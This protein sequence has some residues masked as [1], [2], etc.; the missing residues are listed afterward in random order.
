[1]RQ[2]I[3]AFKTNYAEEVKIKSRI[4]I[5]WEQIYRGFFV[6]Y[7]VLA[8]LCV[9]TIAFAADSVPIKIGYSAL[10]ISLPV[11]SAFKQGFF[12]D[13]GLDVELVRFDTAQPLM[14]SLVAGNIQVAGYTALPITFNSMLRS[15]TK[16]YFITSLYEDQNHPISYVIVPSDTPPSFQLTDLKG[17]NV[18]IL[19]T[20]AYRVWF[21]EILKFHK[22]DPASVNI[23][24]L[25]P[26]MTPTSLNSGQVAALFTNDPAATAVLQNGLGRLLNKDAEV[27]K[28]LGGRFVFGSFNMIKDYADRNPDIARR[29]VR[30]LDKA[31]DFV[32][33]N[34]KE[35]K[36]NMKDF[37]HPSQQPYVEHYADSLY[38]KTER[39]DPAE[40]QNIADKYYEIGI[41]NGPVNVKELV[42][43][44]TSFEK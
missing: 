41:I 1:V 43:T 28:V 31:V 38:A 15:N 40:F 3:V 34:Q 14:N 17:K 37:V 10:R 12:K 16:L 32:N 11:F 21:E 6:L 8:F 7:I 42:V 25:A 23:M 2:N 26:A 13:E 5:S 44:Q 35:A 20:V 4:C 27:P 36:N 29:I 19:P 22:V 39:I 30:A 9:G 33:A 24:P 18:G